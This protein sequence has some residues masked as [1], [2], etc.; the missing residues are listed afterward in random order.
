MV[1][2]FGCESYA[3]KRDEA[4]KGGVGLGNGTDWPESNGAGKRL[5]TVSETKAAGMEK[6][7]PMPIHG[8][9]FMDF[10]VQWASQKQIWSSVSAHLFPSLRPKFNYTVFRRLPA[11]L[12]SGQSVPFPRPTPPFAAS[13]RFPADF[14]RFKY[15]KTIL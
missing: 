7:G 2:C 5:P 10:T 14:L 9:L 6:D 15:F 11:P 1:S 3:G 12:D 13:S 8:E 4:A